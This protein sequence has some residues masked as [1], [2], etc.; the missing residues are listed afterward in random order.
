VI[1]LPIHLLDAILILIFELNR[2]QSSQMRCP[3]FTYSSLLESLPHSRIP[4]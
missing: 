1:I 3:L 4:P 2:G